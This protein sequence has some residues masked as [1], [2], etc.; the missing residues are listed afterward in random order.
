ME[1]NKASAARPRLA[2]A[3]HNLPESRSLKDIKISELEDQIA[4]LERQVDLLTEN[5]EIQA[6][7]IADLKKK[8][9]HIEPKQSDRATIL[10]SLLVTSGGKL[11]AKEARRTMGLSKQQFT[12]LLAIC[13][14]V[15]R[16][17]FHLDKR[18]IV[19]ILR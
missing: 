11:M 15:E 12:N 1:G 8:L 14:F 18:Q 9:Y 10:K 2:E 6:A 3:R 16:K 4:I 5:Q 7:L 19:L 17:P 13:D